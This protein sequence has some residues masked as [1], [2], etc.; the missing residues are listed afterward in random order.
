MRSLWIVG[1][2]AL[3]CGSQDADMDGFD[4]SI[5]CDD[6][7]N[8]VFP[9]GNEICDGIDND[10]NG[11]RDDLY[12]TGGSAFYVD[13][14]GDGYGSTDTVAT[15]CAPPEGFSAN[16]LDCDD[17]DAGV[18]PTAEELC[19]LRDQNCDGVVDE[20]AIDAPTWHADWDQDGFG[21]TTNVLRA[22]EAPSGYVADGQDCNDFDIFV[23]PSADERCDRI[24]ND[25]DGTVDE[26][27]AIDA[28]DWYLDADGDGY[29]NIDSPERA[30]FLPNG[31][32]DEGTD[33][34]DL[35]AQQAPDL[36]EICRDGIDNNCNEL[37]DQCTVSAWTSVAD[38]SVTWQGIGS[39]PYLGYD[40]K[41]VG[42]V[43][44][45]GYDDMLAGAWYE[46]VNGNF[47][48]GR[49]WLVYGGDVAPSPDP[50]LIGDEGASFSGSGRTAYAGRAVA[51]LGDIN[52]D[53]L[54]DFAIG[55]Y[56]ANSRAGEV[57]VVYG[58][59]ERYAGDR[60][61]RDVPYFGL[62]GRG[63]LG[64]TLGGGGDL[65]GDG[66][67]DFT[68]GAQSRNSWAGAVYLVYGDS[69]AL[70]GSYD[71]ED[72]ADWVL[73][74][75]SRSYLGAEATLGEMG[76]F[77]A[78]G[79]QDMILGANR[80]TG[81]R[82]S[83]GAAWVVYGDTT[84]R[85]GTSGLSDLD[86]KLSGE[87]FFRYF[88]AGSGSV[89]DINDDGYDDIGV[90]CYGCENFA[91]VMHVYFGDSTDIGDKTASDA[92]LALVGENRAYLGRF[93]PTAGD[94]DGDG[95]DDVAMGAYYASP[96]GNTYAGSVYVLKG[97]AGL[98]G[99]I[100][101]A[102]DEMDAVIEGPP[103]RFM[104]FGRGIGMGDFNGDGLPDLVAGAERAASGAGQVYLFEG[105][106]L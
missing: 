84:R 77:N 25:C 23:K 85:S 106:S 19:D 36:P 73:E 70:D 13:A 104:Y 63:E 59:A 32:A 31:F 52:G 46:T 95:V 103:Q 86:N 26:A 105:T 5:D 45:D 54:D 97:R 27:D 56:G 68:M 80:A 88:G 55:A 40:V 21:S 65:D 43:D 74:G 39:R 42:D 8:L 12:A 99:R 91:G 34:N 24:D 58:S 79:L 90:G 14:D 30:C 48:N 98:S 83:S 81:T 38:A 41:V 17:G 66:L 92:D 61:M 87:E 57:S 50:M 6:N 11:E 69:D 18:N 67:S 78:D 2:V 93:S 29:G 53:G 64:F 76:D 96:G 51:G 37:P 102:S 35:D 15:A 9:G 89:G 22:C 4:A 33:C 28:R 94:L 7:D 1:L 20:D 100:E 60:G 71:A 101:A 44:G 62:T 82:S 16:A 49:A 75:S 10:C 47:A 3:G 72:D